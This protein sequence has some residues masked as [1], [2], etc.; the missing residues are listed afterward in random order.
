MILLCLKVFFSAVQRGPVFIK[1]RG[2][3]SVRCHALHVA[4]RQWRGCHAGE[5]V[6]RGDRMLGWPGPDA[7]VR[8]S[9]KAQTPAKHGNLIAPIDTGTLTSHEV[10]KGS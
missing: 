2:V 1:A 7:T 10:N 5:S 4:G 8:T 6:G 9:D 3:C